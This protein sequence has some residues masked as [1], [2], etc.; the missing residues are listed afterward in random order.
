MSSQPRISD[1]KAGSIGGRTLDHRV[2]GEALA[3]RA[4]L[5]VADC[6]RYQT[7]GTS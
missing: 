6:D 2:D 5:I 3:E 7:T 4:H 1:E